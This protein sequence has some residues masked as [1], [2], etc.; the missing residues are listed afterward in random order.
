MQNNPNTY[1]T[2]GLARD[3]GVCSLPVGVTQT[4]TR[5]IAN[6]LSA[7]SDFSIS[8]VAYLRHKAAT[9]QNIIGSYRFSPE[10]YL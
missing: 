6:R 1:I 5:C 9:P 4:A 7:H 8:I 2:N 3:S 10:Q